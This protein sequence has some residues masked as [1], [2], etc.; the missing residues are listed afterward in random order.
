[1]DSA[2][3]K[4]SKTLVAT[5]NR[6]YSMIHKIKYANMNYSKHLLWIKQVKKDNQAP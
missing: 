3:S 6:G 5:Y 2:A 1:M 4:I